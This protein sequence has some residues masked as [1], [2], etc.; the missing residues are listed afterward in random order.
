LIFGAGDTKRGRC[1]FRA[2]LGRKQHRRLSKGKFCRRKR[3]AHALAKLAKQKH[4]TNHPSRDEEDKNLAFAQICKLA[5][6][7][8]LQI[9]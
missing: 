5:A 9:L 6:K 4:A 2:A 3:A 7:F 8:E 1:A